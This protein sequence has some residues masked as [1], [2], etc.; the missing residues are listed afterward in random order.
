MNIVVTRGGT[1]LF[2]RDVSAGGNQFT[3]ALQKELS[4]SFDEAE[5]S[6]GESR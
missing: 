1:P 2:T 5:R 3:D 4:L 6:R